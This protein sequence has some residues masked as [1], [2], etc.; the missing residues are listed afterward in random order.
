[1]NAE[2]KNSCDLGIYIWLQAYSTRESGGANYS[3][4][5]LVLSVKRG[6]TRINS[7][8]GN[9]HMVRIEPIS[10]GFNPAPLHFQTM[11]SEMAQT[12]L[13]P[14]LWENPDKKP[15]SFLPPFPPN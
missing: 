14:F 3:S 12:F 10:Q 7:I 13:F 15:F 1:M 6:Q 11:R 2:N 4:S 5:L 8:Q 9:G